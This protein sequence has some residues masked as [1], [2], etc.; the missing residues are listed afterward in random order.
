MPGWSNANALFADA[1]RRFDAETIRSPVV[2][3]AGTVEPFA[4]SHGWTLRVQRVGRVRVAA[5]RCDQHL[6]IEA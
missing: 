1:Y 4:N 3:L 5:R 2:E 6:D